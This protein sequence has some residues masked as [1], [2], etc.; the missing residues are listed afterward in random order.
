ME[1]LYRVRAAQPIGK[2]VY[3]V[4][5]EMVFTYLLHHV[6]RD[7]YTLL[8]TSGQL[9]AAAQKLIGLL[10]EHG[11]V[12]Y[13]SGDLDPDGIGIADRLWQ[14]YGNNICLW[15]MSLEDYRKAG[16]DEKIGEA[17]IA[18]LRQICHPELRRV[19]GYMEKLRVA[20]YQENI[21]PELVEDMEMND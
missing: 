16:S 8:C 18:K 12:I 13:Y 6:K 10:I 5:N 1:N 11:A 20:G 7:S 19:A 3:V 9:R 2:Q 17:G 14:R 4:E 15:R 21:L